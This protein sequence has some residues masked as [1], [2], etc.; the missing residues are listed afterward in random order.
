MHSRTGLTVALVALLALVF[1]GTP[2]L[3]QQK[4]PVVGLAIKSLTNPAYKACADSAKATADKLG[5]ELITLS[6]QGFSALEE[7]IHQV[8]DLIQKKVNAI[9]IVAVDSKGVIP[10]IQ[11]ANKA[12]IPVL[13]VDTSAD[14][15]KLAT[16]IA[17]DNLKAG[18]LA[19]EWM[20]QQLEG[21]G[22]VAMIEGTPGSQQGRD[23]KNGFHETIKAAPGI[24]LVSSIPAN[25]ERAKGMEVMEDILTANPDLAGVFAANDEMA[26]GA[27]EALKQ[28]KLVGKV[29]LLGMNGA[30]EA[31]KAVYAGH[32]QGTV[33]Q[34]M[35]Y[36]CETFVRSAVRAING[37]K[38]PSYIDTGVSIADTKFMQKVLGTL[39][40]TLK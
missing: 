21:K 37:E 19:G 34:Y 5:V 38:L 13:T 40:V 11:E 20:V 17:T 35:E 16:F 1:A 18:R 7:Q 4:G 10:V 29:V 39:N 8:E 15:G 3:S 6:S 24:N 36:V 14:G 32:M 33:V 26:L 22:K 27:L 2:A 12:N 28:R 23:R 25:F 31:L 9:G 30:P